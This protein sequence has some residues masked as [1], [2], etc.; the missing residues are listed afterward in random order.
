MFNVTLYTGYLTRDFQK[1]QNYIEQTC[2]PLHNYL[3]IY[4]VQTKEIIIMMV[5]AYQILILLFLR[6]LRSFNF[7]WRDSLY[8]TLETTF[9][10]I[11]KLYSRCSQMWQSMNGLSCLIS[12]PQATATFYILFVH[13]FFKSSF[14]DGLIF[15]R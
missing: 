8:Q 7:S 5:F 13:F 1:N 15:C 12:S 4:Q 6:Y 11:S 2:H 10:N 9:Y 3:I 14:Q